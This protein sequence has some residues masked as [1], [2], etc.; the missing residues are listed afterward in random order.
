MVAGRDHG[1]A[2]P[3]E[4]D[5]ERDGGEGHHDGGDDGSPGDAV[6]LTD[7]GVGADRSAGA[8]SS[9]ASASGTGVVV[10]NGGIVVVSGGGSTVAAVVGVVSTGAPGGGISVGRTVVG[11]EPGLGAAVVAGE[12]WGAGTAV[13]VG[14]GAGEAPPRT[15]PLFGSTISDDWSMASNAPACSALSS[16]RTWDSQ[17]GSAAPVK[18]QFDPLSARISPWVLKA[19]RITWVCGWRP[20]VG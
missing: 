1:A 2:A 17:P 16:L 13:V 14:A 8:S 10:G 6:V 9:S 11:D 20:P 12:G 19:S 7:V 4:H 15:A 18:Y 5:G 3:E